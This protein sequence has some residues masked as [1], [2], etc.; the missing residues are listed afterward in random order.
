MSDLGSDTGLLGTGLLT[1]HILLVS[2][3]AMTVGIETQ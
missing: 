3:K 1:P 2:F